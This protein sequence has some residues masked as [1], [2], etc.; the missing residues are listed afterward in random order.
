MRPVPW[1]QF[2]WYKLHEQSRGSL[3]VSDPAPLN[4]FFSLGQLGFGGCLQSPTQFAH[5][6]TALGA[7]YRCVELDQGADMD[8]G[9]NVDVG[10]A[11]ARAVEVL[12]P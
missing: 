3:V 1:V 9:G 12:R 10:R 4:S 11:V 2:P 6:A 5:V 7:R 8:N